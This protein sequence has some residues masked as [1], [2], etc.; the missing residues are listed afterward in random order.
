MSTTAASPQ[1]AHTDATSPLVCVFGS[2]NI[3][4]LF[5]CADALPRAGET[6][7]DATYAKAPGGKGANQACA[8]ARCGARVAFVGCVGAGDDYS[9][10]ALRD[11]GVETDLVRRVE[12]G[13]TGTACVLIDARGENSIAVAPGVNAEVCGDDV[14]RCEVLALQ[15]ETPARENKRAVARARALHPDVR[16]MLN[17]APAT[18][19]DWELIL[20]AST[21]CVNETELAM[22]REAYD[23]RE[24]RDHPKNGGAKDANRCFL[25][26]LVVTRGKKPAQETRVPEN[27]ATSGASR[28]DWLLKPQCGDEDDFFDARVDIRADVLEVDRDRLVDT[29]GAGDAFVGAYC[30]SWARGDSPITRLRTATAGGTLACLEPGA[31]PKS[32]A[33][34]RQRA[35]EVSVHETDVGNPA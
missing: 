33:D 15:C 4:H 23:R 25:D 18:A 9:L 10:G 34:A 16:V 5:R 22:L 26:T 27:E 21:V 14:P 12:N 35:L 24:G 17:Y 13:E 32:I 31:R 28:L 2:I 8:A 6:V 11:A 30:A 7:G 3:D 20:S 19:V 1:D 29:V